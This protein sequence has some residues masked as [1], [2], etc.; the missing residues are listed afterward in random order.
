MG[1]GGWEGDMELGWGEKGKRE[2][3]RGEVRG[4]ERR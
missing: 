4:G 1:V 2:K 3:G